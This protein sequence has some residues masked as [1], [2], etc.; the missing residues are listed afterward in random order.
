MPFKLLEVSLAASVTTL[1][2]GLQGGSRDR[3]ESSP[4]VLA[5][6]FTIDFVILLLLHVMRISRL[7]RALGVLTALIS[8]KVSSSPR[9]RLSQEVAPPSSLPDF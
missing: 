7:G 6:D 9:I 3:G 4:V 1:F 8:I 5:W 2:W